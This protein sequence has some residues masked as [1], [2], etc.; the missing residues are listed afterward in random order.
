LGFFLDTRVLPGTA[1]RLALAAARSRVRVV[2]LRSASLSLRRAILLSLP[3]LRDE[4]ER[5]DFLLSR[6]DLPMRM[7]SVLLLPAVGLRV[8]E[9]C[10]PEIE[11][12]LFVI[13]LGLREVRL[14]DLPMI[15]TLPELAA[16]C[17]VPVPIE[18]PMRD[19]DALVLELDLL[20]ELATGCLAAEEADGL[21]MRMVL[22]L[23]EVLLE[24]VGLLDPAD[25][26]LADAEA[27]GLLAVIVLPILDLVLMVGRLVEEET[28]G[29]L[30]V[31]DLPMRA[32]LLGLSLMLDLRL[33]EVEPAELRLTEMPEEELL[34]AEE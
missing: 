22:C 3:S 27:D 11:G 8:T 19:L 15:D 12:V 16:G 7:L 29:L 18:P 2:L 21:C 13:D 6:I 33:T 5:R 31:I 23:R 4:L 26:R 25:E 9:F 1:L 14:F 30:I 28:D 10:E 17:L 32:L 24:L 34:E 20:P